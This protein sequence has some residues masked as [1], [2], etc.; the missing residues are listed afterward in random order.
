MTT[1]IDTN[2]IVALWD[3]EDSLH[4]VALAALERVFQEGRLV[5]SGAVYAELV[6]APGRSETFVD[7]FC[8]DTCITVEW[9]LSERIWR[10]AGKAYHGYVGRRRKATDTEPRRILADFIIGAHAWVN[11]Y[12]LLTLDKRIYGRAFPQL[13]IVELS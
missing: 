1:A 8:E 5:L 2:V 10:E 7:R 12:R 11:G 6:S 3:A 9:Q 13:S 4:P